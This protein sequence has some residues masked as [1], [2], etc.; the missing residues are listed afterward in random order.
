MIPPDASVSAQ[1]ALVPHISHRAN[2]YLFPYGDDR[3]DYI[4]LDVTGDVYPFY[5]S[6]PYIHEVKKVLLESDYGV[7]AAQ[8]GYLLLKRGLP[9]PGI[10]PYSP[11]KS[12]SSVDDLLPNLPSQFCSYVQVAPQQVLHPLNVAFHPGSS[13][14][15]LIGYSVAAADPFSDTA[16][17]M[18]VTTF[19]QVTGPTPQPLQVLA[20]LNDVNGAEHVASFD[21]PAETWCPTN[22][23]QPG[24]IYELQSKIFNPGNAPNGLAHVA[25]ALVP[26][27]QPLNTLRDITSRV[28]FQIVRAPETV[29]AKQGTKALQLAAIT[30]I[31]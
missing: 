18:Q 7:V 9:T 10:S 15:N 22:S 1:S 20:L 16:G 26:L 6:Q 30:I 12:S 27:T 17:Y 5:G 23:W 13:G 8:D 2:I 28:P 4:F 11:V 19:W 25:I 29:T 3:S 24:A 31:P 21:F 14:M